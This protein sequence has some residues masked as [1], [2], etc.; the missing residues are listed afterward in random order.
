MDAEY[1]WDHLRLQDAEAM[2][3]LVNH[4]AEVDGTEEFYSAEDLT[5]DLSSAQLNLE[6]DTIS[7]WQS[8]LLVGIG[9]VRVKS[10]ADRDGLI[11]AHLSG[12][13]HAEHRRRGIGT[14]LMQNL[15]KRAMVIAAEKHCGGAEGTATLPGYLGV[16]G[17][18]PDSEVQRFHESRNYQVARWFNLLTR[19][20]TAKDTVD[21][22]PG[23]RPSI[24]GV[25]I[26]RPGKEDEEVVRLAHVAAFADHWGSA[27]VTKDKWH[28]HYT[29]RSVR[30]EVSRIAVDAEGNVLAYALVGQYLDRE[31]YVELVGTVPAA[32]GRGL[33][34]AVLAETIAAAAAKGD[35][36]VMELDVDSSSLTGA[37]RLYERLGF[38]LKFTTSAMR[39]EVTF[40]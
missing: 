13:V 27:P 6:K 12:G 32:R 15:E 2:S 23:A 5:E 17:A 31:A 14:R 7:V 3:Q 25:T 37:T 16:G 38:E 33:G 11:G 9:M 4:L 19:P 20:L 30:P 29:S 18:R 8:D 28:E 22:V 39:R 21:S 34:A 24:A 36:D 26:R 10:A 1:R 35:Y 40:G